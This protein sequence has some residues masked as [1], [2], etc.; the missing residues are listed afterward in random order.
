MKCP[1]TG[2]SGFNWNY[3][4]DLCSL[5]ESFCPLSVRRQTLQLRNHSDFSLKSLS[6]PSKKTHTAIFSL[7]SQNHLERKVVVSQV[8]GEHQK[9]YVA[10]CLQ[11]NTSAWQ[12]FGKSKC[13]RL[14]SDTSLQD[15][16][17]LRQNQ[18]ERRSFNC[19]LSEW[20]PAM[21]RQLRT[22]LRNNA[23]S[24]SAAKPCHSFSLKLQLLCSHWLRRL[25]DLHTFQTC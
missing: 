25:E 15:T 19:C 21:L 14:G 5:K 13:K 2:I 1:S 10:G 11:I 7:K 22:G 24:F 20:L 3:N 6:L 16:Y 18:E 23:S 9:H 12:K 8:C 17:T 4:T